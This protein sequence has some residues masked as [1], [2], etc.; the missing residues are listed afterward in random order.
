[1]IYTLS[2]RVDIVRDAR[3]AT[4]W[5]GGLMLVGNARAHLW[6]VAVYAAGVPVDLTGATALAKFRREAD[7]VTVTQGADISGNVIS[8]QLHPDCYRY[9]G[10]LKGMLELTTGSGDAVVVATAKVTY[11]DVSE[12]AS[13][14]LS[15]PENI[16]PSIG[17]IIALMGDMGDA[18]AACEAAR[19]AAI[20]ITGAATE[21]AT[22]AESAA[23]AIEGITASA[24]EVHSSGTPY[25]HI[26]QVDGHPHLTVGAK[27]GVD[28]R[29][30]VIGDLGAG[31]FALYV[32]GNGDL[33][34][35]YTGSAPP[36]LSVDVNGDLIW[37]YEEA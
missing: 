33:M 34:C 36:P 13:D 9:A 21:A 16:V 17:E 19:A 18:L 26:S 29:D 12:G 5:Q 28:G 32:D 31:L 20:A 8:V 1:M 37:T 27:N 15:D 25:A 14:Q 3:E 23:T 11:F 7:G 22:R 2:E 24:V 6:Q 4:H 10:Q 30:A 35:E